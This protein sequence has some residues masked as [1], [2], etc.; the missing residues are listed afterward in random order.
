MVQGRQLVHAGVELLGPVA[1]P[2]DHVG[3]QAK[4][5]DDPLAVAGLG[6]RLGQA[7]HPANHLALDQDRDFQAAVLG[8]Q[9]L[10]LGGRLG[11]RLD[12]R[13]TR[14]G[15]AVGSKDADGELGDRRKRI[16]QSL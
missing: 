12:V 2:P 14:Q 6:G 16:L 10:D 4:Q 5:R 9:G 3:H 8:P 7:G 1:Q 11:G 15:H 13:L